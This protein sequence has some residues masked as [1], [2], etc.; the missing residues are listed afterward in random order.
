MDLSVNAKCGFSI[1]EEAFDTYLN[2]IRAKVSL[3]FRVLSV[4]DLGFDNKGGDLFLAYLRQK[5][6]LAGLSPGGTFLDLGIEGI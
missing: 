2:P 3:G 5:E 1:S 6:T 4:N